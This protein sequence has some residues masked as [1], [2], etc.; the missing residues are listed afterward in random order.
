MKR[1]QPSTLTVDIGGTGIKAAVLDTNGKI[2]SKKFL[3]VKT[4][5]PA[6]PQAV[7]KEIRELVLALPKYERI[8]I[9][10]PGVV[11]GGTII[12]APTLDNKSWQG[13]ALAKRLQ[14]ELGKPARIL[15]DADLHG[16]GVIKGK[17]LELVVTLGTGVGTACFRNGELLPHLELAHHPVSKQGETYNQYLGD[18]ARKKVGNKIWNERL[19]H[20]LD[21]LYTLLR[22]DTVYLGGG[23]SRW[24][25]LKKNKNSKIVSNYAAISG[26]TALW[27]S[28]VK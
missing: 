12:T 16:W 3:W 27:N 21:I 5:Q 10:F 19:R 15:N 4:P 26:G 23:N 7:L 20:A 9:G 18:A 17:G 28:P 14:K 6:T 1:S 8:S 13:F 11:A 2:I 24:I 25:T 22:Y